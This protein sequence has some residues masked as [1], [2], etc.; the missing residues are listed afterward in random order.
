[1]S[2]SLISLLVDLFSGFARESIQAEPYAKLWASA[3]R[4]SPLIHQPP[5]TTQK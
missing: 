4:E 1:M 2:S 3:I 5:R